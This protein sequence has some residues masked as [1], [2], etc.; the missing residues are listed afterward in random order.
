MT[1]NFAYDNGMRR[2][3]RTLGDAS[4]A[5]TTWSCARSDRLTA[6]QFSAFHRK[7][8]RFQRILL[9]GLILAIASLAGPSA[10]ANSD[11]ASAAKP[12]F[13]RRGFYLHAGWKYNYPFAVRSWK[14]TDY[15]NMFQLLK[16]L[17]FNTVMMWPVQEAIPMPLSEGDRAGLREFRPIIE[18]AR[19][20]GLETWLAQCP[21]SL[22]APKSPRNPGWS[23]VCTRT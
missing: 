9:A 21:T 19:K 7:G 18:D 5:V 20:C 17:G 8:K 4:G 3:S 6:G 16:R 14:S 2:K 10:R 22:P 12:T 1:A 23:G 13:Q 11:D 15:H